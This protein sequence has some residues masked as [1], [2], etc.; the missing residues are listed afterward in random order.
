MQTV[1]SVLSAAA[2]A[3]LVAA[4][5]G[6]AF[7]ANLVTNGGFEDVT[8]NASPSFF[9]SDGEGNLTGLDHVDQRGF[10]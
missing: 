5:A 9:L 10:E 6:P 3:G 2:L 8:G 1:R 4:D 7:A